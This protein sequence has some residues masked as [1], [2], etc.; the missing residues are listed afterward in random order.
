MGASSCAPRASKSASPALFQSPDVVTLASHALLKNVW[1]LN[2]SSR[3]P[4]PRAGG[5]GAAL[6]SR[7]IGQRRAASRIASSVNGRSF[8]FCG[9]VNAMRLRPAIRI[10]ANG[11]DEPNDSALL[12]GTFFGGAALDDSLNFSSGGIG[13]GTSGPVSSRNACS[14][15]LCGGN[16]TISVAVAVATLRTSLPL[17]SF[18]LSKMKSQ[19]RRSSGR[20]KVTRNSIGRRIPSSS[21]MRE[22]STNVAAR[23]REGE[24]VFG[25]VGF[26]RGSSSALPFSLRPWLQFSRATGFAAEVSSLRTSVPQASVSASWPSRPLNSRCRECRQPLKDVQDIQ[27]ST[28]IPA[29]IA[30]NGFPWIERRP[31]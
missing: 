29:G 31:A 10:R 14:P 6:E 8:S 9:I 2:T 22:R 23:L 11:S 1:S 4:S 26:R 27:S 28:V 30:W 16:S 17:S 3:T 20:A 15:K 25:A 19:T 7:R 21:Q 5:S 24:T 13:F 18:R 12:T